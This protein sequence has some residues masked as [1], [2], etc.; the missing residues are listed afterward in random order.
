MII[1]NLFSKFMRGS[2]ANTS[3]KSVGLTTPAGPFGEAADG[4]IVSLLMGS[5]SARRV[6]GKIIGYGGVTMPGGLAF[7]A[8]DNWKHQRNEETD[9]AAEKDFH[10]YGM[11]QS[12]IQENDFQITVIKVMIAA[13]KA[14]KSIDANGQK[15]NFETINSMSLT[16]E[17]K[18]LLLDLLHSDLSLAEIA[19]ASMSV[20]LKSEIYLAARLVIDAENALQS[21]F[22]NRLALALELPEALVNQLSFQIQ[23][24]L[25]QAA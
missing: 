5:K 3:F 22:L 14:D 2:D 23:Q 24:T 15:K 18:G 8:Y 9:M 4:G 21:A 11:E 6:A 25:P 13:A 20:E 16:T 7:K 12:H 10:R 17:E 19:S 1:D